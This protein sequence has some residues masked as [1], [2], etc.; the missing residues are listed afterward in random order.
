MCSEGPEGWGSFDWTEQGG[1]RCDRETER[2]VLK[3]LHLT[4]QPS[5]ENHNA[6]VPYGKSRRST[7]SLE[8]LVR[9]R[10]RNR[11]TTKVSSSRKSD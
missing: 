11:G 10:S 9:L 7:L 8:G 4:L 3:N 5:T 6:C 1:L 2:G